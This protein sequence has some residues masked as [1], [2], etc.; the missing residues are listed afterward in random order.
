MRKWLSGESIP[1]MDSVRHI[2]KALGVD[3]DWLLTGRCVE[4]GIK[5]PGIVAKEPDAPIYELLPQS[6]LDVVEIMRDLDQSYQSKVLFAAQLAKHEQSQE[7]SR[8]SSA[9]VG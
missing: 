9:R 1:A 5:R 2:A 8:N 3:T 4:A 6:I 7:R